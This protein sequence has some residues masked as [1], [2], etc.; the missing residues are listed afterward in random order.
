M[1]GHF[2]F[3]PRSEGL[4]R[5]YMDINDRENIKLYTL[6]QVK[7]K[8]QHFY[9]CSTFHNHSRVFINENNSWPKMSVKQPLTCN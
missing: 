7:A 1:I 2:D 4:V 8:E 6:T 5:N 3:D 9:C